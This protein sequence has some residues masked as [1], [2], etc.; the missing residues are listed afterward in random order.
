MSGA[1]VTVTN[2]AGETSNYTV[3]YINHATHATQ[4]DSANKA[5]LDAGNNNIQ[6]TY[7]NKFSDSQVPAVLNFVNGIKVQG[8]LLTIG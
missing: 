5:T 7:I 2:G 3:D 1:S 8:Y 6:A 4:A